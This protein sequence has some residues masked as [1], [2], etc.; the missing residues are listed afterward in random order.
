LC[1]HRVTVFKLKELEVR[2]LKILFILMMNSNADKL[3]FILK[4]FTT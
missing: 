1:H 4:G 3:K 2:D